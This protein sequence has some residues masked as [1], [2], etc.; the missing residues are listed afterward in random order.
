[1][2]LSFA[3]AQRSDIAVTRGLRRRREAVEVQVL[4]IAVAPLR[5]G[6]VLREA[7]ARRLPV[8]R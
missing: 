7:E 1:L 2:A 8:A 6:A 4:S 3:L 5:P